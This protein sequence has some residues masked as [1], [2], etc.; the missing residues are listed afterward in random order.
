[1]GMIIVSIAVLLF[2]AV[3]ALR[4][5]RKPKVPP[6]EVKASSLISSFVKD[7][8]GANEKYLEKELRVEGLV[9]DIR[10]DEGIVWMAG[11]GMIMITVKCYFKGKISKGKLKVGD[12][13]TIQGVCK[14]CAIHVI[15]FKCIISKS[16][17]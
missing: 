12:S 6:I 1:M 10:E 9:K 3:V 17:G 4:R 15:L 5:L 2:V 8:S 13:V 11:E 7:S 16:D 14:G